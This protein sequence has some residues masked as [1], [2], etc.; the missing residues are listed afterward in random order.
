MNTKLIKTETD[1]R[2]AINRF[3]KVFQS[4]RGTPEGDQADLLA[5]LIEDYE[6]KHY[7]IEPP[8]PIELN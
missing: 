8:N 1:Y 4:K 5:L 7:A 2:N 6:N 3:S